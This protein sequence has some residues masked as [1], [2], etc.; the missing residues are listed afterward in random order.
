MSNPVVRIEGLTAEERLALLERLWESLSQD[1]A[2]VPVS[3]LQKAELDRRLDALGED[4]DRGSNLGIPWD[5]VVRQ[6]RT[7]G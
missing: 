7:R 1:P 3:D 6:I 4:L 5:E 2:S